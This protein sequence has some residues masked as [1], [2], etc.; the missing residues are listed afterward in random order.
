VKV[1]LEAIEAPLQVPAGLFNPIG[2]ILEWGRREP[3]SSAA[4]EASQ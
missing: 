3:T 1:V 4:R 2:D